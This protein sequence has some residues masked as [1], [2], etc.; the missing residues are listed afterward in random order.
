MESSELVRYLDLHLGQMDPSSEPVIFASYLENQQWALALGLT[1]CFP[2]TP[3][4][5][6]SAQGEHT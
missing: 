1:K 6:F 4:F 5:L 3:H 2:F